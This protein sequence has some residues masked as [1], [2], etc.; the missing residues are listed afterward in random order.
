MKII[1]TFII[2][3][4]FGIFLFQMQNSFKMYFHS[5]VVE[6][7]ALTSKYV[8]KHPLFFVCEV[9]QF[10]Y[11]AAV[12]NGYS[13]QTNWTK[14]K[15]MDSEQITWKGKDG[16]ITF[17]QLFDS[18]YSSFK[19]VVGE[20]DTLFFPRHGICKKVKDSNY[21]VDIQTQKRSVILIVDPNMES[22]LRVIEME[23]GRLYCGP[24]HDDRFD[25]A[26]YNI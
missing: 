22:N 3:L 16:N 26:S 4:A 24:T 19:S 25:A 8:T 11:T 20:T 7:R 12:A 9:E 5:P 6:E 15:L 14:G 23:K 13:G 17:D 21:E 2:I 10:N 18:D 1:R